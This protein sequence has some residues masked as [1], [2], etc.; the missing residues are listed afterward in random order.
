MGIPSPQHSTNGLH[1][2]STPPDRRSLAPTST[3]WWPTVLP[4]R[5]A[6]SPVSLPP[7]PPPPHTHTQELIA[8]AEF[9]QFQRSPPPPP[10]LAPSLPPLIP[11]P[12]TRP[13]PPPVSSPL[14][15]TN[16]WVGP[17]GRVGFCTTGDRSEGVHQADENVCTVCSVKQWITS[18]LLLG[19]FSPPLLSFLL[20]LVMVVVLAVGGRW[21]GGGGGGYWWRVFVAVVEVVCSTNFI[22]GLT[23]LVSDSER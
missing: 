11:P 21:V 2:N 18:S 3:I 1:G 14:R 15:N 9:V 23:Y 13:F 8:R 4:H 19:S 17:W 10:Q 22:W 5:W 12:P 20:S 16:G 7:P 6:G